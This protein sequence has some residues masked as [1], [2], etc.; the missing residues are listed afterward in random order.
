LRLMENDQV[1]T[2]AVNCFLIWTQFLNCI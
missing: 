1:S 2:E